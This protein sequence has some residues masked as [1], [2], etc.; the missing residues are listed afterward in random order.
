[1]KR[2]AARGIGITFVNRFGI[3]RELDEGVLRHVPLKGPMLSF[4]GI[5]VRSARTLPPA[6]DA[7]IQIATDEIQRREQEED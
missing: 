7:F 3:E 6:V 2:F 1:M 4:L 5:Y